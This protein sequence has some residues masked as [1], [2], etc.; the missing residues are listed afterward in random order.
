MEII[1]LVLPWAVAG[2][3]VSLANGPCTK[4]HLRLLFLVS[5]VITNMGGHLKVQ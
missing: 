5:S 1:L 2:L 4:V 3:R